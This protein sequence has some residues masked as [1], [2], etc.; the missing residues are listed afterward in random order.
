[1]R[2]LWRLHAVGELDPLI[3]SQFLPS[4]AREEL[5]D[6][7]TDPDQI[8]NIAAIDD[9]RLIMADMRRMM[10]RFRA[11]TPDWSS[12]PEP[13]MVEHRMWPGLQ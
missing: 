13:Q 11:V 8:T 6:V 4:R 10:T 5:Y 2:E 3:E 7:R 12:E 9:Q 1:M